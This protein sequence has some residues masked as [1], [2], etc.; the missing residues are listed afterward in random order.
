M[1]INNK[2]NTRRQPVGNQFLYTVRPSVYTG[3]RW[4]V[5]QYQNRGID[6]SPGI[7]DDTFYIVALFLSELRSVKNS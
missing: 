1:T 7:I 4:Y 5:C 6:L 2:E 3:S